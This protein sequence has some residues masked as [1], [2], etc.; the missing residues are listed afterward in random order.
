MTLAPPAAPD[1]L[2]VAKLPSTT[3]RIAWSDVAL[4]SGYDLERKTGPAGSWGVIASFPANTLVYTNAGLSPNTTYFYRV[5]AR[6][7]VGSSDYSPTADI[8]TDPL[9]PTVPVIFGASAING[10]QVVLSWFDS[11][12]E[13][14][15]VMERRPAGGNWAVLANLPRN[16]TTL[17][18]TGVVP[19]TTYDYRLYATNSLGASDYSAIRSVSTPAP[20]P[21]PPAIPFVISSPNSSTSVALFWIG[22]DRATQYVI[23]RR[24]GLQPWSVVATVP[25]GI[26]Y[27]TDTGLVSDTA[28]T[29]RVKALNVENTA[30][31]YSPTTL[32]LTWSQLE[33]WLS[34]N[35][36][37]PGA[38][39][40]ASG[41]PA[42]ADGISL[43]L[44]Y[45]F[46]L[47]PDQ[48][49][50]DLKPDQTSG[51]PRTWLDRERNRLCVEFV[52][53]RD[54]SRPGITYHVLA[55]TNLAD[56]G[57]TA[58]LV[59]TTPID[60]IWERARYENTAEAD[61]TTAR[62]LRVVV[63]EDPQ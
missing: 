27:F 10:R 45:A 56:W 30:G 22:V 48:P 1:T 17:S 18:D 60:A 54:I 40:E 13:D 25:V 63:E 23:E 2:T 29:Y 26:T 8:T 55:S 21:A 51:F 16:V 38:L 36:G 47:P 7:N 31:G 15:Y 39:T 24:Q 42:P 4:E 44:R 20:A 11:S 6:N 52:R 59:S 12:Y 43:L 46:N 34:L 28:Y 35:Y 19:G 5:R 50:H 41:F 32:C 9:P 33:E 3:V 37:D 61:D 57:A 49:G 62:Y 58:S 53:R 14:G